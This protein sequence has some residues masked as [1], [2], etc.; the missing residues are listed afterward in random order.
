MNISYSIYLKTELSLVELVRNFSIIIFTIFTPALSAQSFQAYLQFGNEGNDKIIEIETLPDGGIIA[1][2]TFT[3]RLEIGDTELI[4]LGDE[5]LWLA[6][7][8]KNL[9]VIWAISGGSTRQDEITDLQISPEGSIFWTGS[10]WKEGT[11]GDL[12]LTSDFPGKSVFTFKLNLTG[13]IETISVLSGT[14]AKTINEL[15]IE[16]EESIFMVGNFSDTLFHSDTFFTANYDNNFFVTKMNSGFEIEWFR[17]VGGNGFSNGNTI[18]ILPSGEIITAG[19]F[20]GEMYLGEDSIGTRTPDEDIFYAKF[21]PSGEPLFLKRAGGVFPG[22]CKK[23]V[24]D[25]DG[26]FYLAGTHRGVIKTEDDF[27]IQSQGQNDNFYILAFKEDGSAIWGR[28]LGSSGN[29]ESTDLEILDNQ[30]FLSGFY[31][32][33]MEIDSQNILVGEGFFN[34]FFAAFSKNTG[35]LNWIQ[36]TTGDEFQTGNCIAPFSAKAVAAGFDFSK[37]TEIE[38]EPFSTQGFFD[39]FITKINTP[40]PVSV[41]E[42]PKLQYSIHPNPAT[43]FL[44]I[45]IES[46][47]FQIDFFTSSGAFVKRFFNQNKISLKGF[48]EGLLFY[49]IVNSNGEFS[50]G[51]IVRSN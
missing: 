14:G 43:D 7:F 46:S 12:D 31:E 51:K 50:F 38:N 44:F 33:D 24:T 32:G 39:F 41:E 35:N 22:F 16:S 40:E 13:E 29:D 42:I 3:N 47:D 25:S 2:G 34:A 19:E 4:S 45:E 36:T 9:E 10:F 21:L 8:D 23:S 49:K 28:S 18:S 27:Q 26:N 11:F 1:A 20:I 6:R 37:E 15:A 48:P 30:L 5:D 17:Q